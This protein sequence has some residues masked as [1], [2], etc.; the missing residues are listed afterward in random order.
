MT[1]QI[2]LTRYGAKLAPDNIPLDF[3]NL[4]AEYAA[5][6]Q[7]A[8]VM[9]RSHEGRLELTG[10]DRLEIMHRISTNNLTA[11][12]E[13][14]GAPTLF[15]SPTARIIDRAT[16][17]NRGERALV[18]TEPG[19][20][21]ALLHYLQ[22]SI[23]FNDEAQI[24]DLTAATE[25]L[26]VHGPQADAAIETLVPGAAAIEPMRSREA[27]IGGIPAFLARNKPIS[28]SHWTVMIAAADFDAAWEALAAVAT[29]AG[30]LAYNMLRIRAGRP[31]V[32]RELSQ[33]YIP[34]EVG[35]WDEVSFHKGCYTGQEIIAR[36]ES[37]N[38]LARIM[39]RLTLD[40]PVTAPANLSAE[41]RTVGTVTSSVVTADGSS[42]GIGVV[43]LAA[44]APGQTLQ[45]AGGATATIRDYAGSPPPAL[46]E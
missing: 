17:Y 15:T 46:A 26:D 3:G 44:A 45:V 36:M 5:A 39:V 32:G 19:R 28:G 8:V 23:F 9:L 29:P 10:R 4:N 37:R 35:L 33:D 25:Q 6:T 40:A 24:S 27:L 34:L 21:P 20:G 38:R 42:V 11:L 7:G 31:G 16:V 43:K 22:R 12:A 41:G 13:G 1:H 2:V 30:S 18:I 14:E